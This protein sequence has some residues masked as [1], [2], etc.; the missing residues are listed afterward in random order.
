MIADL[1][2][3]STFTDG[4]MFTCI[5]TISATAQNGTYSITG[6]YADGSDHPGNKI[7]STVT[8]GSVT[9]F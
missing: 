5:F 8:N 3:A 9:V 4:R 1:T 6:Q 2:N 7:S